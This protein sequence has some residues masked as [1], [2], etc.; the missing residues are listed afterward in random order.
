MSK[1]FSI[2]VSDA[3]WSFEDKLS[4]SDVKRGA[5]ANYPTL[6]I[7]D[8]KA[9]PVKEIADPNG[10]LLA[11]W[12]PS[13]LLQDGLDTMTAYGFAQKQTY[14]WVKVKKDIPNL[15]VKSTIKNIKDYIKANS[16]YFED[17]LADFGLK[18]LLKTHMNN[19]SLKNM[20]GFNLGRIF[21]NTH[22]ICLIGTN[23]NN[24]YQQL[25]NKSQRS[26]SFATNL[27]HSAK[28][29]HLQDSLELMFPQAFQDGKCVELFA[30]R[31]RPGWYCLG[32]EIN[33]LDIR[34]ALKQL[35][36]EK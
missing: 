32:N 2:V 33:G 3:P 30:R 17:Y 34:E 21:R 8:I 20:L 25:A 28:P 13:S 26:V 11:L 23:N 12:V 31:Q 16:L 24:I 19:F 22:E 29:E 36:E 27:K 1:K 4:M 7:A 10:C 15:L 14:I 5:A 9:L 35:I 6:S 18:E